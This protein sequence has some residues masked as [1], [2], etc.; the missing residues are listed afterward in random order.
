[1]GSR[2]IPPSFPSD[3][4]M[5]PLHERLNNFPTLETES[6]ID[7]YSDDGSDTLTD[8]TSALPPSLRP[9]RAPTIR[10][11]ERRAPSLINNRTEIGLGRSTTRVGIPDLP[12]RTYNPSPVSASTT[13]RPAV[14][15]SPKSD[16]LESSASTTTT[17]TSHPNNNPYLEASTALASL[18]LNHSNIDEHYYTDYG[19]Y[20]DQTSESIDH[21]PIPPT[22]SSPRNSN[23]SR[24]SYSP[25]MTE[26][27]LQD[28]IPSA[29]DIAD[30]FNFI[31][32]PQLSVNKNDSDSNYFVSDRNS[33]IAPLSISRQQS[34]RTANYHYAQND[35]EVSPGSRSPLR[36]PYH[37]THSTSPS[38]TS[39]RALPN[40]S[41]KPLSH[42][43]S[44]GARSRSPNHRAA[45]DLDSYDDMS[46]AP[47]PPEHGNFA[48]TPI[49][50]EIYDDSGPYS[51]ANASRSQSTLSFEED[52]QE[53]IN[54]TPPPHR[55][56]YSRARNE[57][58]SSDKRA[59][60]QTYHSV[61][62]GTSSHKNDST[63]LPQRAKTTG[64]YPLHD[65]MHSVPMMSGLESIEN[66][67]SVGTI[68]E[69][70]RLKDFSKAPSSV[71]TNSTKSSASSGS[72]TKLSG[73]SIY[74]GVSSV[75]NSPLTSLQTDPD[76]LDDD[77]FSKKSS[78]PSA[79]LQY[80]DDY[81]YGYDDIEPFIKYT[82]SLSSAPV[83]AST[84]SSTVAPLRLPSHRKI[85]DHEELSL[86]PSQSPTDSTSSTYADTKTLETLNFPQNIPPLKW[87]NSTYDNWTPKDVRHLSSADYARCTNPWALSNVFDWLTPIMAKETSYMR[88][89]Q[90]INCLKGLFTHTVSTLSIPIADAIAIDAIESLIQQKV[91]ERESGTLAI[92]LSAE[93]DVS[94]VLVALTGHGCYS[95]RCHDQS[96]NFDGLD[97]FRCYC[98]RCS[99]SL[100][101]IPRKR[102]SNDTKNLEIGDWWRTVPENI[103]KSLDKK[104]I[105]RQNIMYET[106]VG[107]KM[108]LDDLAA[109]T[110][111]FSPSQLKEKNLGL[112]NPEK[113][114]KEF[115][116]RT[117]E[118]HDANKTQLFDKLRQRQEQ[119][120]A[121]NGFGDIFVGWAGN[122]INV[123]MEYVKGFERARTLLENE[124]R[125]NPAFAEYYAEFTRQ[126]SRAE[127]DVVSK[128]LTRYPL[129]LNRILSDTNPPRQEATYLQ[130]AKELI[131]NLAQDF[132]NEYISRRNRE[133]LNDLE[134]T[135]IF[136]PNIPKVALLLKMPTRKVFERSEI[137]VSR[138]RQ[139]RQ[140]M[141]VI[142]FDNYLIMTTLSAKGNEVKYSPI[143]IDYLL[144]LSKDD[145]PI[146]TKATVSVGTPLGASGSTE[147]TNWEERRANAQI[148]SNSSDD[149]GNRLYPFRIR[150]LGF[151][152]YTLFAPTAVLREQWIHKLSN[153]KNFSDSLRMKRDFLPF[154]LEII[155]NSAFIDPERNSDVYLAASSLSLVIAAKNYAEI[156]KQS[157]QPMRTAKV[158]SAASFYLS[159]VDPS[160]STKIMFTLVGCEYGVYL[161]SSASFRWVPV[162][163]LVQVGNIKVIPD[164][165]IAL[166]LSRRVLYWYN[167]SALV[168]LNPLAQ[169]FTSSVEA[170]MQEWQATLAPF[171]RLSLLPQALTSSEDVA[172]FTT[173]RLNGRVIVIALSRQKGLSGSLVSEVISEKIQVIEPISGRLV[174]Y[175][176]EDLPQ[177]L[178]N[179]QTC[180]ARLRGLR[181]M[182]AD[183]RFRGIRL[184]QAVARRSEFIKLLN[185]ITGATVLKKTIV[186]HSNTV[187]AKQCVH[188]A[189]FQLLSYPAL[190]LDSLT[191]PTIGQSASMKYLTKPKAV[192]RISDEEFLLCY[193][194]RCVITNKFGEQTRDTV[195]RPSGISTGFA[196]TYP[197]L[198]S[199]TSEFV[200]V[201]EILSG[202]LRQTVTGSRIRLLGQQQIGD[203]TMFGPSLH[204]DVSTGTGGARGQDVLFSVA[205]PENL[206]TQLIVRLKMNARHS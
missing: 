199:F 149:R 169:K 50:T 101:I 8:F 152:N 104:E 177:S 127:V 77:F 184:G 103:L 18:S 69:S 202:E 112:A 83:S 37:S 73:S 136:P 194:T 176:E 183:P 190:H 105:T 143:P 156:T 25:S 137:E 113:F 33:E 111:W 80:E 170:F 28:N 133:I 22:H 57:V 198:I 16:R 35:S 145:E 205:S 180:R 154:S 65:E 165:G 147:A 160:I 185:P 19:L 186:L 27:Y 148:N 68:M 130:R 119:K 110:A 126:N 151:D 75:F 14:E 92:N 21:S 206:T 13:G 181:D 56:S 7:R 188:F 79:G 58:Q 32:R 178:E 95:M 40:L 187:W 123:Y 164:L 115:L 15:S 39:P 175:S 157:K 4:T 159:E 193:S 72:K 179:T 89:S 63:Y 88:E 134:K 31:D 42:Q 90:V 195:I 161:T 116:H 76:A 9:A 98:P 34:S 85:P 96:G 84:S 78:A 129:Q 168:R 117:T 48:E 125:R 60:L 108:F 122:V 52:M 36:S 192:F 53:N 2:W 153:A 182:T 100:S 93:S 128:R 86:E 10:Q 102:Q 20:L 70:K 81:D 120:I 146:T 155:N 54:P 132:E 200:E 46:H 107:E 131:G 142:L 17:S 189:G 163:E 141:N 124:K 135:I 121:M 191:P 174:R 150:H 3:E 5:N 66:S 45:F 44:I 167:L 47:I 6:E 29:Q 62:S 71:R 203:S 166:I 51:I 23:G 38:R 11:V 114:S 43:S 172:D 139:K 24:L 41:P 67:P 204:N 106:I 173:G 87:Q 94:G 61:L 74:A 1:M 162:L 158:L 109:L 144:L 49:A 99:L 196:I 201:F 138:N 97:G 59:L 26:S 82:A 118:L 140:M 91:L 55:I 171:D 197:Y 12:P 30:K 64:A